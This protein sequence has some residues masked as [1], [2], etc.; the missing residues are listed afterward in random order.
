MTVRLV[1]LLGFVV[2]VSLAGAP[3]EAGTEILPHEGTGGE[4]VL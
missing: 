2:D 4:F 3:S 1:T